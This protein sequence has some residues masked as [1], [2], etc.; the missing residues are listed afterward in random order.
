MK[1]S[2]KKSFS[3]HLFLVILFFI[4]VLSFN[5]IGNKKNT[6]YQLEGFSNIEKIYGKKCQRNSLTSYFNILLTR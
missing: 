3:T 2:L 6:N 5:Y 1:N 4:L